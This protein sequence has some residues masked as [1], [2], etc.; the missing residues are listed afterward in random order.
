ML[1]HGIGSRRG[2]WDPV[3]GALEASFDVIAPDLPGFGEAPM[4]AP[5]TPPGIDSLCALVLE[6]LSGL[7]VSD[8]HVAGNSMGAMM[9]LELGRW[10][11]APVRSV[12]A[13]SP[14]GFAGSLETM[15]ERALLRFSVRSARLMAPHA[16]AV[17]ARPRARNLLLA[18][19]FGHPRRVPPAA[20]AADMRAMA[21]APWFDATLPAIRPWEVD[22]GEID[23]PVTIGWGTLDRLLLPHQAR[24]AAQLIPGARIVMLDD[25]GHVPTWDDPALVARVMLEAAQAGEDRRQRPEPDA[26][27][28][29]PSSSSGT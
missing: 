26:A 16:E 15:A 5:G 29:S 27:S 1:L 18:T 17:L 23:V 25:C 22:P 12:C 14:A 13:L 19:F 4:P 28:G 7:G 21:G 6:F 3:L 11:Q 24:R 9:A 20:A 10:R 8:F 2:M